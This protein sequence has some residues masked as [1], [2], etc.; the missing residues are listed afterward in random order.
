MTLHR[1]TL[2][3]PLVLLL[4]LPMRWDTILAWITI[5]LAAVIHLQKMEAASWLQQLGEFILHDLTEKCKGL[6]YKSLGR[7]RATN[8][9]WW[10]VC[11]W[12]SELVLSIY[13]E[14]PA[15]QT[16]A[17]VSVAN[18]YIPNEFILPEITLRWHR[19]LTEF[20]NGALNCLMKRKIFLSSVLTDCPRTPLAAHQ[21][22]CFPLCHTK[23]FI[24]P[25]HV[26]YM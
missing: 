13:R 17:H 19:H 22:L 24:S 5:Q 4:P 23:W 14:N 21:S 2:I 18:W 11:C 6:R 16:L 7:V 9:D 26:Q 8:A 10:W 3:M 25:K 15:G 20:A 12:L 1:I